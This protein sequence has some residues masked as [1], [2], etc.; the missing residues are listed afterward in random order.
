[1]G[2]GVDCY[3]VVGR[4]HEKVSGIIGG[5]IAARDRNRLGLEVIN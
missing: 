1:M 4:P 3:C 5:F 2:S